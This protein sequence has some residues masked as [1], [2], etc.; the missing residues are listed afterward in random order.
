VHRQYFNFIGI[1]GWF[2]FGKLLNRKMIGSGEMS[3]FNKLVPVFKI[4]DQITLKK[5][6][7]SVITIGKKI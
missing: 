4:A 2:F 5:A 6:G 7:L 1:A 3:A